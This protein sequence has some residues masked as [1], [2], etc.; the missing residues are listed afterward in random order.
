MSHEA[1]IKTPKQLI[2]TI[3]LSFLV[4]IIL[5][6]ML[7][8]WVVGGLRTKAP[9]ST[10][11]TSA[12]V[13]ARI[14]PVAQVVY[15]DPNAP[16]VFQTGEQV[17]KTVC[18]ACHDGGLAGAPKQGDKGMWAD[19]LKLGFDGLVASVIKGKGA[20]APK[21][22]NADLDDFEIAR[23]VHYMTNAV[24]GGFAEPK[25][26]AVPAPA[27]AAAPAAAPAP[28]APA[29]AAAAPAPAA[30]VVAAT[31]SA[32]AASAPAPAASAVNPI[33]AQFCK[34]CHEAGLAGAPKFGDKAAW[35][36]RAKLGIDALLASSIKG[37]GGMP[38]KGMAMAASDAELKAAIQYMLDAAK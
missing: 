13:A 28:A 26:P 24:G 25:A 21:G 11:M 10:S 29:P 36:D 22:G 1:F 15:K 4:P 37:K 17:Y 5:I 27:V 23:A 38:P 33:Y 16:K 8:S 14:A 6:A 31:T 18:A 2:I 20:M 32:P 19:R 35:A 7:A 12:A 34:M 3:V 9:E 30:P